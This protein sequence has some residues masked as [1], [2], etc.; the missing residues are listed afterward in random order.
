[1]QVSARGTHI[2]GGRPKLMSRSPRQTHALLD[3]GARRDF[4]DLYVMLE[5]HSLGLSNCL[6]ALR[7]VYETEVN[8]GLVLRA[9]CYFDDADAELALPGEG[10]D[11][12]DVVKAYFSTAVAALIVPPRK[13]LAIQTRRVGVRRKPRG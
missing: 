5:M 2:T 8:D 12:W 3:R 1:L 9:P 6:A 7:T 11:D 13:A 10:K 4:F